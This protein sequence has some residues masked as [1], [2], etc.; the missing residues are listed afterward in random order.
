[1][2]RRQP[3]TSDLTDEQWTQVERFIPAPEPG[4]QPAKTSAA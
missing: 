4:G 2:D 1:M 3:Y